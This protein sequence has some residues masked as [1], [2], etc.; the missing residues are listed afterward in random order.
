M[1]V[2]NERTGLILGGGNTKLQTL[3]SSFTIGN[4]TLLSH[5]PGDQN[6]KFLEPTGLLHVPSGAVLEQNGTALTLDYATA[7]CRIQLVL[8]E[9]NKA[10]VA[11]SV[12]GI[13]DKGQIEAHATLLPSIG[14][15]WRTAVGLSGALGPTPL[16][17]EPEQLGN[18][19]EHNGWRIEIPPHSTLTWPALPHNPYRKDGHAELSEGR[20]VV[21]LHFSEACR[22][23]TVVVSVPEQ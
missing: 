3:W 10:Q 1:S 6:P 7:R 19:F 8:N 4:P 12:D 22:T 15:T 20:I 23:N 9:T 14:K 18:W 13:S 11:Y 17:L 2:F 21:T 16:H 5:K